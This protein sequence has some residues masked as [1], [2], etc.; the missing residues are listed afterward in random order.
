MSDSA[1]K[2]E[3]F[4][5]ENARLHDPTM[6]RG[7]V[8]LVPVSWDELIAN[9][10]R[11]SKTGKKKLWREL[12]LFA[13]QSVGEEL[14]PLEFLERL[15]PKAEVQ[16]PR[17]AAV[18]RAGTVTAAIEAGLRAY[19]EEK[20]KREISG[21]GA[22]H[23]EALEKPQVYSQWSKTPGTSSITIE[24]AS[25]T[26]ALSLFQEQGFSLDAPA[27][28]KV[29][30]M[31]LSPM[32]PNLQRVAMEHQHHN[33]FEA[34]VG[35]PDGSYLFSFAVDDHIRLDP[36]VAQTVVLNKKGLFAPLELARQQASFVL[37]NW[38]PTDARVWLETAAL[39]LLPGDSIALPAR[40]SAKS[41]VRLD[42]S[43]MKPGLNEGLL[44]L[45]GQR[46][47]ETIS[48]GV[49]KVAV[50]LEVGGAVGEFSFTPQAFG[51]ILQGLD[52]VKLEVNVTARGRG[53]LNGMISLPQSGELIDFRL[54]ADDEMKSRFSHT[55]H[56]HSSHL[57]LPQPNTAEAALKLMILTDSFLANY[58]L[59]RFEIPYRLLYLKKSLPALSF[60]TIRS[61]GTKTMRLQVERSD[62][63]D[64]ELGVVL[65]PATQRFLEA[66]PARGNVFV[67]RLDAAQLPPGTHIDETIELTDRKSG[68]RD[69]IKILATITQSTN[70][71]AYVLANSETH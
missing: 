59:C 47:E 56:I 43:A 66:Y 13:A 32:T 20:R 7:P 37:T 54:D 69:R 61:S 71:P 3:R 42:P 70:E 58:R 50:D 64:I 45:K 4:Q 55:F 49:V 33:H 35:L 25:V 17:L 38:G 21:A 10:S 14:L 2:F 16:P 23:Q 1:K 63:G 52:E 9:S 40:S 5:Q 44:H 22:E 8:E 51:E 60:G 34:R 31:W 48:V 15:R 29:E 67:F 36:R 53:P 24:P 65:P 26:C 18:H 6:L 11:M 57:P 27:A 19:Q 28:Q 30:L 41:L 68:L 12:Y 39:W 46:G 62:A